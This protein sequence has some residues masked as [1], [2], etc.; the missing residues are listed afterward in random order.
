M[1]THP[2]H[3]LQRFS[4]KSRYWL[5]NNNKEKKRLIFKEITRDFHAHTPMPQI[6]RSSIRSRCCWLRQQRSEE[7]VFGL[8]L[9]WCQWRL[10]ARNMTREAWWK[11]LGL[12]YNEWKKNN[13]IEDTKRMKQH[14]TSQWHKRMKNSK[15]EKK[16]KIYPSSDDLCW[17]C[18]LSLTYSSILLMK[19]GR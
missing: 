18:F 13:N 1:P 16:R 8:N 12:C 7:L 17:A 11:A 4:S 9:L 2:C 3:K 10:K 14:S 19:S 5:G 15:K 6:T